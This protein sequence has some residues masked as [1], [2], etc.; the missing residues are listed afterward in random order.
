M[1]FV[2]VLALALMAA[3]QAYAQQSTMLSGCEE[4]SDL[5]KLVSGAS[6]F[7]P[8]RCEARLSDLYC[9]AKLGESTDDLVALAHAEGCL[10]KYSRITPAKDAV[11]LPY[12][13]EAERLAAAGGRKDQPPAG[14]VLRAADTLFAQGFWYTALYSFMPETTYEQLARQLAS[15]GPKD[16]LI[17]DV[18]SN[19]GGLADQAMQAAALFAPRGGVTLG[20]ARYANQVNPFITTAPGPLSGRM[21][22]ILVDEQT[23]SA[24]ELF[25][26][27]MVYMQ[28]HLVTVMGRKTF[29]KASQQTAHFFAG[30]RVEAVMTTAE[31]TIGPDLDRRV[32]GR[33]VMPQYTLTRDFM[34]D[35]IYAPHDRSVMHAMKY[36]GFFNTK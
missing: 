20:V 9:R 27:A 34:R 33:G 16:R 31:I 35:G 21:V 24:A 36:A 18:R 8:A 6:Y 17:I 23:A 12:L 10:D 2:F 11:I 25:T 7:I 30:R 3:L 29:G 13:L 1:R 28:P 19:L 14:S 5:R 4:V 32:D 26:A 22:V 15:V